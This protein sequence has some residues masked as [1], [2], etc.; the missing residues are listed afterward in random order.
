MA[1]LDSLTQNQKRGA[2]VVVLFILLFVVWFSASKGEKTTEEKVAKTPDAVEVS[3]TPVPEPAS[4]TP[5]A[6]VPP[7]NPTP[8]SVTP[9]A[10]S[11][12]PARGSGLS[13]AQPVTNQPTPTIVR[14]QPSGLSPAQP[15]TNQP[16]PTIAPGSQSSGGTSGSGSITVSPQSG[17]TT[18]PIVQ[19]PG[20]TNN[21]IVVP[22]YDVVYFKHHTASNS[23]NLYCSSNPCEF[24][25]TSNGKYYVN[26]QLKTTLSPEKM[27]VIS[28][29]VNQTSYASIRQRSAP[30]VGLL[31]PTYGC[32]QQSGKVVFTFKLTNGQIEIIDAC[33]HEITNTEE[34]FKSI[35]YI[36]SVF[37]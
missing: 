29:E 36:R 8:V 32:S 21:L 15:V 27:S 17:P 14:P 18:Q 31:S 1:K 7:T 28:R 13:P 9:P 12:T 25:F 4:P 22:E 5:R 24:R 26:G 6:P 34:P 10:A 30:N 3:P 2:F 37:P 20:P 35:E 19:Q 16:Q 11:P 33:Q 23:S